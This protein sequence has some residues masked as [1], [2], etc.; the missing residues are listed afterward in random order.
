M[1]SASL[2]LLTPELLIVAWI[3]ISTLIGVYTTNDFKQSRILAAMMIVIF[4]I[5]SYYIGIRGHETH[6]VFGNMMKMDILS[7]FFKIVILCGAIVVL[8]MMM[9]ARNEKRA[10]FRFESIILLSLS[11]LGMMIFVMAYNYLIL[12]LGLELM[13]LP[14]YILVAINRD[15]RLSS[16][17]GIKYFVLGALSSGIL[18]FGISLYY[19]VVHSIDIEILSTQAEPIMLVFAKVFIL[20]AIFFKASVVPFHMWA[21][22]I[23]EGATTTTVAFIASASKV[24]AIAILIKLLYV[25]YGGDKDSWSAIIMVVAVLSLIVGS[26][27]ALFQQNIKRLL[28]YS[29]IA[30]MGFI[31]LGLTVANVPLF[32]SA[33][34]KY[35]LIYLVMTLG[36]FLILQNIKLSAH[37]NG[38]INSLAGFS[39]QQPFLA[40]AMAVLMFSMAGI[41][42]L[43]GFFAKLYII[44]PLIETGQ[45]A[46]AIIAVLTS[47]VA[48][49]YYLY[50]VKV[51]YFDDEKYHY[52]LKTNIV[53]TSLIAIFVLLNLVF[54]IVPDFFLTCVYYVL[55]V[56]GA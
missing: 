29:S 36:V 39:R 34:L 49:F 19:G 51:M 38:S 13:S 56:Y 28:A 1:L 14:L 31:L 8:A 22:D 20:V 27:G 55:Q 45:Y 52:S 44:L 18:L 11:V 41:P 30:H 35:L 33:V 23:Y 53:Y 50:N 12:Y 32:L 43:A 15:D 3:F 46:L 21:P 6:F 40:F 54:F 17:A 47:V 16:E 9:V 5:A 10:Y 25:W 26:F 48:A 24:A 7:S 4:A 2:S 37:Y 42:P